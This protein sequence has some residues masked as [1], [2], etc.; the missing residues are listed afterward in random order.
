MTTDGAQAGQG[1]GSADQRQLTKGEKR[2]RTRFNPDA[3]DNVSTLKQAGAAFIDMI[4]QLQF[5]HEHDGSAA[6]DEAMGE[7]RRLKATAQTMVEDATMW[8]VKAATS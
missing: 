5:P 6:A 8:A 1:A 7:F 3:N 4:E 2:V